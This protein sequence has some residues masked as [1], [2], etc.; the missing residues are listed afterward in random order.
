SPMSPGLPRRNQTWCSPQK[1]GRANW[2][3]AWSSR[4]AA[5]KES[6]QT[7]SLPY[8]LDPKGAAQSAGA[9]NNGIQL[10]EVPE[11]GEVE[12]DRRRIDKAAV[13]DALDEAPNSALDRFFRSGDLAAVEQG[14]YRQSSLCDVGGRL[15]SAPPP[16][17]IALCPDEPLKSAPC[18]LGLD[19]IQGP[20]GGQDS[21]GPICRIFFFG[22]VL[23]AEPE[24]NPG[25]VGT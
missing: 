8:P 15:G 17:I 14:V 12:S 11:F 13:F 18:G 20:I 1:N 4:K 9:I 23:V 3:F 7:A 5:S 21:R 10:F 22:S 6:R 16:A 19:Q 25:A 2:Q 24:R